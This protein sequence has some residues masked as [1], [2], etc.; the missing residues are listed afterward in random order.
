MSNPT[1][2]AINFNPGPSA[3]PLPA[4]ERAQA[5]L[6]DFVGTGMSV[7]EHSHRGKEYEAVHDEAIALVRE[8]LA[9]PSTHDLIF[10]QGGAHQQFAQ[11]PMNM[12]TAGA[13]A[14]YVLTGVWGEKAFAEA[15]VVGALFGAKAR[16]AA[17]TRVGEGKAATYVRTPRSIE[18]SLD[19]KAAYV[20]ITS[21]ET[22]HG[23]EYAV[24]PGATFPDFGE[25]P[26]V[27]DM[28]SDILW[29]PIDVSRFSFIYAGA[30]KNIGPSGV[31]LGIAHKDFVARGRKDIPHIFQYRSFVEANSLL[32]T[33]PTFGIYLVRNCAAWLKET[34]GLKGAEARNREKA[35]LV[36]AAIDASPTF[37]KC[38]VDPASRS[39]MNVVFRLPTEAL[40]AAF[41]SE[42]KKHDM[43]GLKGH[44]SVGGIRVSLYNAVTV[45]WV[46]TLTDFMGDFAS[47]NG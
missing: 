9:I 44:R 23:V 17:S 35:R 37:Y 4:L 32:N 36:Y 10:L 40:E 38:P 34:G 28:S 41:V 19:P 5:E 43:V 7:M 29:R 24:A 2:R 46:K 31:V 13:S 26:L 33:P 42:A 14:D 16:V 18:L 8:L 21:N 30:Q 1:R 20:H 3:L 39:V 25:A 11:V 15:E 12:L 22:I 27:C 6:L 45:E 47:R